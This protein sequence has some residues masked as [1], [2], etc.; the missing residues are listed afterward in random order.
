[1]G[2]MI[3]CVQRVDSRE[4]PQSKV[5]R[6]FDCF[7]SRIQVVTI[8]GTLSSSFFGRLR[9]S[10]WHSG[11]TE[12]RR[13]SGS[14]PQKDTRRPS[15]VKYLKMADSEA[16]CHDH[17]PFFNPGAMLMHFFQRVWRSKTAI[18]DAKHP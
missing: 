14:L 13:N 2:T 9:P 15:P 6:I 3:F 17:G 12:N 10:C 16:F 7:V 5:F 1:M 8:N 18:V 4:A 11:I